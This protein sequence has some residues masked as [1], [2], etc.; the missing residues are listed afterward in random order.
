MAKEEAAQ[1]VAA[2]KIARLEELAAQGNFM[3]QMDLKMTRFIVSNK[4]E[5]KT[6]DISSRGNFGTKEFSILR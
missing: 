6:T 3:A 4:V 2:S 1:Q 5:Q